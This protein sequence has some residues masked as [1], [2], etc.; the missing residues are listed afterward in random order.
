M[1]RHRLCCV[2]SPS[3]R[4]FSLAH[5]CARKC[6]THSVAKLPSL[7]LA[8]CRRVI[9]H[10]HL[11]ARL[12]THTLVCLMYKRACAHT[13]SLAS[14]TSA[15]AH[16]HARLPY[17]QARLHVYTRYA[18]MH[19]HTDTNTDTDTYARACLWCFFWGSFSHSFNVA[20]LS[21]KTGF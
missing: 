19:E 3:S 8:S 16:T 5:L 7:P 6:L 20:V 15:L 17:V 21:F 12:R 13:R 4:A 18:L 10:A 14:C 1:S 2:T 11:H 9:P